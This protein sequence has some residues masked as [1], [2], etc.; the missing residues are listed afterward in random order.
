MKHEFKTSTS[1]SHIDYHE[2]DTL[3]IKFTSGAVHHYVKCP[4]SHYDGLK[5][6][7]SPGKYF[8]KMIKNRYNNTRID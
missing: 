7:E 5:G 1:I 4:K 3:E 2:P 6:A 8:H